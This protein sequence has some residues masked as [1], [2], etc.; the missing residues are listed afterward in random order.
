MLGQVCSD[1][2]GDHSEKSAVIPDD[3]GE[4]VNEI[5]DLGGFALWG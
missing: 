1:H 5:Q 2:P 4:I 3:L